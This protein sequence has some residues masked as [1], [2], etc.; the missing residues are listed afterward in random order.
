M[1]NRILTILLLALSLPFLSA[2]DSS[3]V[4]VLNL[5]IEGIE[6]NKRFVQE[7]YNKFASVYKDVV[8]A[9]QESDLHQLNIIPEIK[10]SNLLE[11]IDTYHYVEM[12]I[13]LNL[14]NL[15]TSTKK[16]LHLKGVGKYKNEC[17]AIRKAYLNALTSSKSDVKSFITDFY[18]SSFSNDCESFVE[19]A[20]VLNQKQRYR[21]ALILMYKAPKNEECSTEINQLTEDIH[22]NIA[23]A[24][25]EKEIHALTLIVN[26]KDLYQIRKNTY[27]LLR[28]PPDAP[29]AEEAINLSK[30]IGKL[31]EV[32][33]QKLPKEVSEFNVFIENQNRDGWRDRYLRS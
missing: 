16:E 29:C 8:F 18:Q 32:E 11:G 2:Q 15:K 22:L 4:L 9:A 3:P 23:K 17:G 13:T 6:C 5:E 24:S 30:E 7:A 12:N 10:S 31:F 20:K 19:E 33:N 21:E 27:K 25:C 14:Q 1:F 26:T 28:I